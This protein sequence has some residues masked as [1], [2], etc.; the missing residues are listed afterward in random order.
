VRQ[1]FLWSSVGEFHRNPRSYCFL[2]NHLPIRAL[3]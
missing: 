3:R 1:I 2:K